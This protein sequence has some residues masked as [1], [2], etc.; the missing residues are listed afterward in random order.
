MFGESPDSHRSIF[1][2][3]CI[4]LIVEVVI[5]GGIAL[6]EPEI[7]AK[8]AGM[9]ATTAFGGLA[10]AILAGL[11]M[12]LA[13]LQL[14]IILTAYNLMHLC[15]FFPLFTGLYHQ[16]A[17]MKLIGKM[18]AST[19][20]AARRHKRYVEKLGM[21]GLPLFIWLPLP[22]TGTLMGAIVGYLMGVRTRKVFMI[23]IPTMLISLVSWIWGLDYMLMLTHMTTELTI[24]LIAL[25]VAVYFY[26]R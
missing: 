18:A 17:E 2:V 15:L 26:F 11:N 16:A 20:H 4:I 9:I 7:V 13:P 10:G 14:L 12:G 5:M 19:Q 8:I 22:W 3:G 1:N 25:L 23:A 24:I 6:Y 21:V